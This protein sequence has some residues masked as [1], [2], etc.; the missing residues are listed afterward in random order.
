MSPSGDI[1]VCEDG[2]D[3]DI[4]LITPELEIARFL[5]LDPA[6]HGGPPNGYPYAGNETVG[7][8]FDPAGGRMYF[9]AQRSFPLAFGEMPR[10][11]VYEIEGPFREGGDGAG[12]SSGSRDSTPPRVRLEARRRMSIRRLLRSGLP[13]EVDLDEPAGIEATLRVSVHGR[14]GHGSATIAKVAPGVAVG[15]QVE[16]RLT[17]TRRARRLL[18]GRGH[19]EAKLKL[20]A[21]D[22][23]GNR[24]VERRT[25][26]LWRRTRS[27][28]STD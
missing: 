28:G 7:V 17:P 25:V 3:R 6:V 18:R 15:N 23:E 2:G 14:D 21:A 10:G 5:K 20:V 13:I 27:D 19:V 16:L 12:R 8:V 11:A 4:C 22:A 24:T 9:G 1:Y 26:E